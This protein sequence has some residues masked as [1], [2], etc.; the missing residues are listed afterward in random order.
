MLYNFILIFYSGPTTIESDGQ[1]PAVKPSVEEAEQATAFSLACST[2]VMSPS[3]PPVSI[4]DLQQILKVHVK[5][6]S[7]VL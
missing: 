3:P 1:L 4:V 6:I 2:Q 7:N 5:S